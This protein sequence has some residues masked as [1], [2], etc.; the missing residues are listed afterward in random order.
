MDK[1]E[2]RQFIRNEKRQYSSDSIPQVNLRNC[3]F[4]F[5]PDSTGMSICK[6]QKRY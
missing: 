1:K 6:E 5:Y 4:L 3:R 2:L